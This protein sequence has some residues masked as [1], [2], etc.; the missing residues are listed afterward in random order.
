MKTVLRI[1]GIIIILI[2]LLFCSMS[3]YRAQMD[4][5]DLV[6]L[7]AQIAEAKTQMATLKEQV[8]VM[9]GESKT[10][11][12]AEIAKIE[13]MIET[14]P[15]ATTYT[16]VQ[17]LLVVLII[18]SLVFAVFLF[19][20]NP[21]LSNQLFMAAVILTIVTFFVSPDLER[22]QYSGLPSRTLALMSG[23]PVVIAG[24]FAIFVAKKSS[25]PQNIK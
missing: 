8:K 16:I 13:K 7:Q 15:S 23:I 14:V 2:S 9:T 4:K 5:D 10:E 24:L 20:P 21:K 1:F 18:L 12:D 11:L 19:K 25:N 3:I 17:V 22:G 6:E